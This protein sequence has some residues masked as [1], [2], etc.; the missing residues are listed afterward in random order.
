M[1]LR[2]F[3]FGKW[4]VSIPLYDSRV[5]PTCWALVP[6]KDGQR[7]HQ[8]WHDDLE[9]VMDEREEPGGYIV[10]DGPLPASVRGG[11]DSDNE[12]S[13]RGMR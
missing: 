1:R 7:N 3:A 13:D 4:P 2:R 11:S 9:G 10:G 6:G 12:D 5:C 8:M